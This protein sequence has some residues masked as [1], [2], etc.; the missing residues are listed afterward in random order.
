MSAFNKGPHVAQSDNLPPWEW[1]RE[2]AHRHS[3][4][5]PALTV[6]LND[7]DPLPCLEDGKEAQA[8][9]IACVQST[10]QT[11]PPAASGQLFAQSELKV[12]EDGKAIEAAT[13]TYIQSADAGLTP[14]VSNNEIERE[15]IGSVLESHRQILA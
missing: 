6:S 3:D 2:R 8:R 7:T 12:L 1:K 4:P 14:R 5:G 13:T 11:L 10:G 9:Q 15:E